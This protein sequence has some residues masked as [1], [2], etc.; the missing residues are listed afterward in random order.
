[1]NRLFGGI[2]LLIFAY[3]GVQAI[4]KVSQVITHDYSG[5]AVNISQAHVNDAVATRTIMD[6]EGG[7]IV[8]KA[9]ATTMI[10]NSPQGAVNIYNQGE[11]AGSAAAGRVLLYWVIGIV[12][13]VV[14]MLSK[15]LSGG[16]SD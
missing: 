6:G 5:A 12:I 15:L 10:S 16:R 3:L 2:L 7:L 9:E 14:S 11:D 1:M 13:G 4:S 8:A